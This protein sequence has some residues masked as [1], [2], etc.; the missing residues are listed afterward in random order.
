MNSG[1]TKLLL[2]LLLAC[3]SAW[4]SLASADDEE[5]A[6]MTVDDV[7]KMIE[8]ITDQCEPKPEREHLVELIL[9][10][11]DAKHE[12]KCL[13]SCMLKQF[14]LMGASDT[15]FNEEKLAEAM[16]MMFSGRED[17][18]KRIIGKCN[19]APA[20]VTDECETSHSISMCIMREMRESN[21][22]IPD[23]KE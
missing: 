19:Q 17:D 5:S 20:G 18:S 4:L 7:I 1:I 2:L 16:N 12:T 23:I 13:R 3:S 10:K 11:D 6:S 8:F 22:E 14:E 15:Q 21:Y 9:S